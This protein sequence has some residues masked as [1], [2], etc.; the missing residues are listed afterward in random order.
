MSLPHRSASVASIGGNPLTP[1]RAQKPAPSLRGRRLSLLSDT[2][3]AAMSFYESPRAARVIGV[4]SPATVSTMRGRKVAGKILELGPELSRAVTATRVQTFSES[5]HAFVQQSR[6]RRHVART[7]YEAVGITQLIDVVLDLRVGKMPFLRIPGSQYLPERLN[8][9]RAV[10]AVGLADNDNPRVRS[11]LILVGSLDGLV[12]TRYSEEQAGLGDFSFPSDPG[13]M[14]AALN[15]L[16]DLGIEHD[17]YAYEM[18][19]DADPG[20]GDAARAAHE[21]TKRASVPGPSGRSWVERCAPAQ[22]VVATVTDIWTPHETQRTVLARPVVI[23]S[24]S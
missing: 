9:V 12:G 6:G 22:R 10:W 11:E 1:A 23:E 17:D 8:G 20:L 16:L 14:T 21:I 4:P 3:L 18:Q 5:V 24:T 13:D 19:W 15:D 7:L 2:T